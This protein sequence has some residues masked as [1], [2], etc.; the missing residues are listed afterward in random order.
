MMG[1]RRSTTRTRKTLVLGLAAVTLAASSASA[2]PTAG[3]VTTGSVEYLKTVAFD[4]GGAASAR[5]VGDHLYV[6]TY[7]HIS[8]YDVTDPVDPK[9]LSATP[10]GVH[11]LSM[12]DVDT[13][14]EILIFPREATRTL[15][16]WD[17]SD[18][19]NPTELAQLP[20]AGDHML[21]C[22]L[23][24]KWAYGS[25]PGHS[26]V[27]LRD[28]RSPKLVG[29]W[30][31]RLEANFT[32]DVTEVAPGRV[33]T[34]S[35]PFVYYLDAARN[36]RRPRL[37]AAADTTPLRLEGRRFLSSVQWPNRAHDRFLLIAGE[38]PL[39]GRCSQNSAVF[40][41]WDSDRW[42]QTRRFELIDSF[43]LQNGTYVDG[44]PA[45]NIVGCT[46][47]FFEHHP[48]FDAGGLVTMAAAEHGTRFLFVDD[49]GRISE[50]GA[51]LPY[52]GETLAASWITNEIVYAIDQ[53]RGIDILRYDSG[54]P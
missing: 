43:H 5:L 39:S 46:T 10:V 13:N 54:S 15:I 2:G 49:R 44:N 31:Q 36:P 3:G 14:G 52:G 8:I 25:S 33:V 23:D 20:N 16:V 17:V 50:R 21:T 41:T 30:S 47:S 7:N 28:P 40:S 26:I 32:H 37:L 12:E 34:A 11:P 29:Q 18:P 53:T 9:L 1:K 22:V 4:A 51:F 45:A 38:T 19:S 35:R 27:D 48:D 24:C 6:A 42:R